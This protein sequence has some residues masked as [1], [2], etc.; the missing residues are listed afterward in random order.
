M[1]SF[2]LGLPYVKELIALVVAVFLGIFV[3]RRDMK[4]SEQIKGLKK[5][6]TD[7]RKRN[8]LDKELGNRSD[9][10]VNRMLGKW[11]RD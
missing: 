1:I 7:E 6:Y 5:A 11:N 8:E 3:V 10:D 9:D 2:I 4:K